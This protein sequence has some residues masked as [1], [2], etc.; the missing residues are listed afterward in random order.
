MVSRIAQENAQPIAQCSEIVSPCRFQNVGMHSSSWLSLST[1]S[2]PPPL[3]FPSFHLLLYF[4]G[5]T[6]A[7]L[8]H[9]V[10]G[11]CLQVETYW[12]DEF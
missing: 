12:K 3:S 10:A 1:D 11:K 4:N 9:A 2:L 6:A 7:M 8:D 5:R